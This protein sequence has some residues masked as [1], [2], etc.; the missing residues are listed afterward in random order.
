M[1]KKEAAPEE[2]TEYGTYEGYPPLGPFD[3]GSYGTY[4]GVKR[5]VV[6]PAVDAL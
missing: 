3:S 6:I 5:N 2:Y 4:E 1:T